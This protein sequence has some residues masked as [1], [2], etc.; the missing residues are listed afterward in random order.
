MDSLFSYK[1][2]DSIIHRTP[3]GLKILVLLG[4]PVTVLLCPIEVCLVLIAAFPILALVGRIGMKDFLR[5]LKPVV[6]YCLM[7]VSIDVLSYLLFHKNDEV[8]TQRSFYTILRLL[9]AIEATS[10]FFR[11]TS[12]HE[13]GS[14]LQTL[15][16][17]LTFGKSRL[18]LSGLFSLFLGFLPQIFATWSS[19][20]L[21][22]RARGGKKGLSKALTLFP[23]LVTMSMKKATTTYLALLNRS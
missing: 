19:L 11:T 14:A 2:S 21:A 13:I 23:L 6:I 17:I 9:C 18:V 4:V 20:D 5:D 12:T 16:R 7:I 15:E 3:A 10:V 1:A 22:Y 8:V